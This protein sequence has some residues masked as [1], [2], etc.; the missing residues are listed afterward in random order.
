M[1]LRKIMS[2]MGVGSAKIDLVLNGDTFKPGD[3]IQGEFRIAGG[4]IEQK[5]KRIE[6]D[7]IRMTNEGETIVSEH[8]ILT[9]GLVMADEE[10]V[11]TFICQLPN[12]LPPTGK[13]NH[14]KFVTK[15][16][17]TDGV[18]SLDH[19]EIKILPA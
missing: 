9:S 5:L 2:K 8:S 3:T 14:Y 19:D 4:I 11:V 17:F 13:N 6:T 12:D 18:D 15:L 10:K 16:V 7:L 1:L